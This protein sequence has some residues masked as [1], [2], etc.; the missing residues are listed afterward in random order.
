MR[1]L[2]NL[3]KRIVLLGSEAFVPA[4]CPL[5]P[6]A[7][8]GP[9]E[10]P[11]P[12]G[13]AGLKDVARRAAREAERELIRRT[14]EETRWNRAEAARRLRISYKALLYKIRDCGL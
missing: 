9:P 5:A 10:A 4:A 14:L 11:R 2:E 7:A 6:P 13:K 3:V 1:E 12:P 8:P